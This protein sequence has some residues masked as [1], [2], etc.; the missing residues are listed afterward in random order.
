MFKG[1]PGIVAASALLSIAPASA[2]QMDCTNANMA[3][4]TADMDKMPD[5][6]MKTHGHEG[7]DHGEGNDGQERHGRL[8]NAH[9]Q[10]H[11][12]GDGNGNVQ[13]TGRTLHFKRVV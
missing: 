4:A 2:A 6:E 12:N 5:G 13:I 1:I 11:G 9:E 10:S 7:N 3:K 8:Q